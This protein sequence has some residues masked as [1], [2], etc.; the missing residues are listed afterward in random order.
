ML[1]IGIDARTYFF[2][3]GL[4]RYCRSVVSALLDDPS[5]NRF[6]VWLSD[7]KTPA[8]FPYRPG[9]SL[10]VLV[11]RVPFGDVRG[12]E[13]VLPDEVDRAGVDVFFSPY[14]LASERIGTPVV[15]TVH[16]L[17]PVMF[18]ALHE[19]ATVAYWSE[20]LAAAVRHAAVIVADSRATADDL[21]GL[22]PGLDA[23][24]RIAPLAADSGF[25]ERAPESEGHA[26]V[27]SLGLAWKQYVLFV[28]SLEPRKNLPLAIEAYGRSVLAG[29]IPLALAGAP[30][31]GIEALA[32]RIAAAPAGSVMS[33][34]FVREADLPALYRG[35]F[36]FLYPSL[37]EGFGLPVLEAMAGGVPVVT[38]DRSSMAEIAAGAALLVDPTSVES[39]ASG[40]NRVAEDVRLREELVASGRARASEYSWAR[41]GQVVLA[42]CAEAT[43]SRASNTGRATGS[44]CRVSA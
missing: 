37:Y 6:V 30:R 15:Q 35:A 38:S 27:G 39:V 8:D 4:G 24:I 22:A 33:L 16:D 2:R 5:G 11:S 20:R 31:W 1:T 19:P 17:T 34:G 26:V 32:G 43:A 25:F 42:A 28:G 40:L 10:T 29:R 3:A 23:P 44:G 18:P 21:L 9:A 7:Q 14:S 36:L 12:E 41:T 13:S